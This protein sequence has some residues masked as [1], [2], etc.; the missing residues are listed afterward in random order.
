MRVGQRGFCI[1]A[2]T[3]P[4]DLQSIEAQRRIHWVYIVAI[5]LVQRSQVDPPSVK[6]A[7]TAQALGLKPE[8]QLSANDF[9]EVITRL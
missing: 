5:R 6:L 3:R 1:V 4:Q 8:Y 9:F 2:V 7:I